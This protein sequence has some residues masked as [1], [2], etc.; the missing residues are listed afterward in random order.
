MLMIQKA[1]PDTCLLAAT[2]SQDVMSQ[3]PNAL[4]DDTSSIAGSI[5]F[6]QADRIRRNPAGHFGS[7]Y[8]SVNQDDDARSQVSLSTQ[9]TDF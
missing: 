7:D 2:I 3:D 4:A 1:E 9:I 5:A 8:K 6:S